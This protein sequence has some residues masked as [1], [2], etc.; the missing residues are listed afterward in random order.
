MLQGHMTNG[1]PPIYGMLMDASEALFGENLYQPIANLQIVV[2]IAAFFCFCAILCRLKIAAPWKQLV[3]FCYGVSPAVVGW[4]TCILTE[5]FSISLAVFF[6]YCI[7]RYI[8]EQKLAWGTAA[9]VLTAV[10][11]FLRT[12][13]LLYVALLAVFFALKLIFP[14]DKTERKKLLILLG[15]LA[16]LALCL[17]AY[18]SLF[19]KQFGIFSLTDAQPRQEMKVCM[20]RGYYKDFEDTEITQ[21]V[22]EGLQ[23]DMT[24]WQVASS[25]VD[26]FGHARVL[27]AAKQYYRTHLGQYL[28][29]TTEVMVSTFNIQMAGYSFSETSLPLNSDAKGIF[30]T[31]FHLQT[32]LFRTVTVAQVMAVSLLEGVAMLAVWIRRKSLPWVHA[33]LFSISVCTVFSVYF[34]TCAEYMRTMIS[35]MPYF[36]IIIALF[37]DGAGRLA[38]RIGAEG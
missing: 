36:Y 23:T 16:V 17:L 28:S 13:F 12:Q 18:A 3:A 19:Q 37:L 9:V 11:I 14:A 1:R 7:L 20:D 26:R 4:E 34:T 21:A 6:F 8:Q 29:D 25:M 5:S 33:A 31:L 32:G 24:Q 22:D 38:A 35:V 10:L 27:A 15:E 30:F 2:S